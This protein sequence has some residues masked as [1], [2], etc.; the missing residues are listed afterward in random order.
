M[1]SLRCPFC[2]HIHPQRVDTNRTL[3]LQNETFYRRINCLTKKVSFPKNENAQF[4]CTDNAEYW[5]VKCFFLYLKSELVKAY[6]RSLQHKLN[7]CWQKQQIAFKTKQRC[8]WHVHTPFDCLMV[9]VLNVLFSHSWNAIN[10]FGNVL[11]LI[12]SHFRVGANARVN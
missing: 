4:N 11:R 6:T 1:N 7:I 9:L 2:I 5:D 12:C 10:Q 8:K 3:K